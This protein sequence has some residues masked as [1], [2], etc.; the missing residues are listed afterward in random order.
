M[1]FSSLAQPSSSRASVLRPGAGRRARDFPR[2][3]QMPRRKTCWPLSK[4][5]W[6]LVVM[7]RKPTRSFKFVRAGWKFPRRS[8]PGCSGDHS[9]RWSARKFK[10]RQAVRCPASVSAAMFKAGKLTFTGWFL[11]R[12][13]EL[14]AGF[15]RVRGAGLQPRAE[16][17]DERRRRFHQQHVAREAAVIPPVGVD[18]SARLRHGGGC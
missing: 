8:T 5:S 16:I 4:M 9:A 6:P 11:V 1:Q 17:G 3:W 2:G 15:D 7:V 14:D 12:A 10:P 13:V 18:A